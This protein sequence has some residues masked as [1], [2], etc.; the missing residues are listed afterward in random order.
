MNKAKRW[1]TPVH[2]PVLSLIVA[3]KA[4]NL[5]FSFW[6]HFFLFVAVEARQQISR[7][8]QEAETI[9]FTAITKTT[10]K[11]TNILSAVLVYN[12]FLL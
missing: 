10:I 11:Y 6:N 3:F 1:D 2:V 12:L 8:Q 7:K 4:E 9:Q 5:S